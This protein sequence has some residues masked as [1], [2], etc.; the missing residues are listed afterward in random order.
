M[1]YVVDVLQ[2]VEDTVGFSFG[3]V[4]APISARAVIPASEVRAVPSRE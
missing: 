2:A 4:Y 3:R 1:L